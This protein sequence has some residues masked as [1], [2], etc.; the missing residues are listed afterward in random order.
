[1]TEIRILYQDIK[2]AAK[3]HLATI[4]KHH[5]AQTGGTLFATATL[6]EIEEDVM[7]E[8]VVAAAQAVVGELGPLVE[9]YACT[10]DDVT[11]GVCNTRMGEA[12]PQSLADSIRAYMVASVVQSVLN[13]SVPDIAPKY[14]TDVQQLLAALIRTAFA[15]KA[16]T[17]GS[18]ALNMSGSTTMDWKDAQDGYGG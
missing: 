3:R 15:K 6:S 18:E 8:F 12:L 10:A 5:K 13:M 9:T 14:A 2:S 11:L 4:G 17:V 1:M 7:P 16:P